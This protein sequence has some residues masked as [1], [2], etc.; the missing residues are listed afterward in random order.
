MKFGHVNKEYYHHTIQ[1]ENKRERHLWHNKFMLE[2][3]RA[4]EKDHMY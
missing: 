1:G 4:K 3:R 2:H